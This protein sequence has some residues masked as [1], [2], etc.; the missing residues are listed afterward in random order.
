MKRQSTTR[1]NF[2][3]APVISVVLDFG[4]SGT[5]G[6]Y[7]KYET[8][9]AHSLF[10]EPEVISVRAESIQIYEENCIGT[11][12]YEN[13]AWVSVKQEMKAVGYLAESEYHGNSGLTELKYERAIYKTLAAIW[14]IKEKLKLPSKIKVALCT[15]L[16]PGEFENKSEFEK[17]LRTSSTDYLTPTGRMHLKYEIFQC[18][19]EGAGV[20]LSHQKRFGRDA[21]KQKISAVVMIGFRNASI[22]ISRRGVVSREGK[23]SDLGMV[24]M[25]DKVLN[26]SAGQ[27]IKNLTSAIVS[28]TSTVNLSKIQSSQI[29]DND[30]NTRPLMKLLRSKT[31]EGRKVEIRTLVSAIYT[32]KSEYLKGVTNWLDEIVP[33]DVDEIIFCGGTAHY[34]RVE[35]DSHF[36][37]TP[38]IFSENSL[39]KTIDKDC[40]GNRLT[41]V[42]GA[43]LYFDEILQKS[44]NYVQT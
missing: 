42:Y 16:P 43:F 31:K 13:K 29:T 14:V 36:R 20:F 11:T 21:L 27:D 10:M 35:L 38:C 2:D 32:A 7:S 17:L 24:K 15:L 12:D 3:S 8:R 19:P 44:F 39:P 1:N 4:G 33:K 34:L 23:T 26:R 40:L 6:I 41:D 5:K 18:L 30:I 25:I 9:T 28:S 22:L 37:T